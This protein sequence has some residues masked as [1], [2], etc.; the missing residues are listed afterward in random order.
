MQSTRYTR[1]FMFTYHPKDTSSPVVLIAFADD[2]APFKSIGAALSW[3]NHVVD[4]GCS[5]LPWWLYGTRDSSTA[6]RGIVALNKYVRSCEGGR[7]GACRNC[8]TLRACRVL[9]EEVRAGLALEMAPYEG[10]KTCNVMLVGCIGHEPRWRLLAANVCAW[11]KQVGQGV[12]GALAVLNAMVVASSSLAQKVVVHTLGAPSVL[13][14]EA[15]QDLEAMVLPRSGRGIQLMNI[16]HDKVRVCACACVK[17]TTHLHW[18]LLRK[19]QDPVPH[20]TTKFV[21]HAPHTFVGGGSPFG[22]WGI[23]N[24]RVKGLYHGSSLSPMNWRSLRFEQCASQVG[25]VF[26]YGCGRVGC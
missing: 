2:D 7:D 1:G 12:G 19:C 20:M 22:Y 18:V 13:S 3:W 6:R 17:T 15:K 8:W 21:P 25:K 16:V 10:T 9:A 5:E 4:T 23:F 26:G 24:G 11:R 14:E